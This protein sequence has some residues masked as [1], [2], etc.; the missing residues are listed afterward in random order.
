M[1]WPA[2][3]YAVYQRLGINKVP[4]LSKQEQFNLREAY[5]DSRLRFL[6][7]YVRFT[8]SFVNVKGG[9]S[10]TTTAVY[11]G[12]I[13]S[14]LTRKIVFVVP[15]TSNTSTSTL[16]NVA[17]ISSD[18][19]PTITD[20]ALQLPG[21]VDVPYSDLSR[22][23]KSTPFGL[24]VIPEDVI[25]KIAISRK[26]GTDNFNNVLSA[27][28]ANSDIQILD[29]GNDDIDHN[30]VVLE[31]VR[32]SDIVVC[33]AT[34]TDA[35]TLEKL[36]E[37]M[38]TYMSDDIAPHH[39]VWETFGERNLRSARQIP[40]REKLQKGIVVFSRT[41]SAERPE[42]YV[43]Y[44]KKRNRIG[45]VVGDFGFEGEILTIPE[46]PYMADKAHVVADIRNISPDTRL[47]YK[48]LAVV[49]FEK[50]AELK[51]ITLPEMDPES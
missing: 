43:D 33:P 35:A 11:V 27:V 16:A 31:A 37:T 44:T 42:D 26:F 39:V 14:D 12:S 29:T 18:D 25:D 22:R 32:Q 34:A 4:G 47:A 50:A 48:E 28:C 45:Q 51:G 2:V 30:S 38:V 10:K 20:F 41:G 24:R 19:K 15:A 36:S 5:L 13:I 1:G 40:T 6:A 23:V 17:G 8:V 21:D 7:E 46:D 9:A 3:Q 49:M